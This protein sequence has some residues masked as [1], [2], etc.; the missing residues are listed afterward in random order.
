M[1]VAPGGSL[2]GF[3]WC[4][5]GRLWLLLTLFCTVG[6]TGGEN[7]VPPSLLL[8]PPLP[9]PELETYGAHTE[10][11]LKV[12]GCRPLPFPFFSP[13]AHSHE[14]QPEAPCGSQKQRAPWRSR[15][16]KGSSAKLEV[17][18]QPEEEWAK[19]GGQWGEHSYQGQETHGRSAWGDRSN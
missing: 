16:A 5:V 14:P 15:K 19:G 13:T 8:P 9:L 11:V 10:E 7:L 18:T 4:E 2:L 17:Y 3:P 12:S 6:L 1:E